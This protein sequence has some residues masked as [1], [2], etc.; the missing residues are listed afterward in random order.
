[1]R[2]YKELQVW[3]RS[4]KLTLEVY[5]LTKYFPKEEL[6]GLVSQMRRCAVSIPANIAEGCG[7]NSEKDL[8]RF[9]QISLGSLMELDYY[10]IL[11]KDLEYISNDKSS[12]MSEE[13]TQLRKMLIT[14]MKK[15]GAS[16]QPNT[17]TPQP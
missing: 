9:L 3:E 6:F 10:I 16:I 5:R 7:K 2:N 12:Q 13:L 1:M 14:F 17:H 11:A 8:L 4:H 15:V